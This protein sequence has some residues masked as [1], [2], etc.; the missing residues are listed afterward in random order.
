MTSR[1]PNGF[2]GARERIEDQSDRALYEY[3]QVHICGPYVTDCHPY[4]SEIKYQLQDEGFKRAKL[5]TDRPETTPTHLDKDSL[6]DQEK[7][8]LREFWTEVSYQFLQ[9]AD[10]AIFF[11]L[12][13]T[14]KRSSLPDRAFR[15]KDSPSDHT[16][17]QHKL[18]QDPNGS[19]FAELK[20]WLD[21]VD[22]DVRRTMVLFEKSNYDETGSLVTGSVGLEGVHWDTIESNA[23]DDG[24][25]A[26]R[27]RCIN[28]AMNDC[29]LRLQDRYYENQ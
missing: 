24:F 10:V 26:V 5:C 11:F 20:Y 6:T 12:D 18:T 29:K 15:E 13:P 28:W 23:V 3:L 1:F 27:S 21:Q 16:H 14:H 25:D 7:Q 17:G 19:V 8:E 4:L 2:D 22:A 9:N